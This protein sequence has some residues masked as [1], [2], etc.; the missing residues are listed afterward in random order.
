MTGLVSII[1][2]CKNGERYLKYSL[3]SILSQKYQNWELIFVDNNSKDETKKIFKKYKDNRFKYFNTKQNLK[4]GAARQF[5]LNKCRGDFIAFLD[6]DDLWTKSK[7]H[8]QIPKFKDNNVGVVISNTVFFNNYKEFIYYK[9]PPKTG[10]IYEELIK[11]Y[12]I[13]LETLV[14]RKSILKKINFKFNK[15]FEMISDYEMCIKLSLISKVAYVDKVLAKWRVHPTSDSW[16]KRKKFF[17][18]KIIFLNKLKKNI[19]IN[20]K[21]DLKRIIENE[22]KRLNLLII[23]EN[24]HTGASKSKQIY[25]IFKNFYLCKELLVVLLI[26]FLPFTYRSISFIKKFY[27]KP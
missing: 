26:L 17:I 15:N 14:C 9:Y 3:K 23:Q 4:L 24:L 20:D 8:L 19:K 10:H 12:N 25:K 6:S 1:M 7:L 13:N 16:N 27:L 2:N 5:A 22:K 21:S 18:E 11:N